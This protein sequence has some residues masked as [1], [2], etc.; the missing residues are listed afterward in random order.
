MYGDAFTYI[1]TEEELTKVFRWG[2][3]KLSGNGLGLPISYRTGAWM[4]GVNV[5]KAAQNAGF[6]IDTTG[7]TGGSI[8]QTNPN[9]LISPWNLTETTY[10]YLPSVNDINSWEGERLANL[11]ISKQRS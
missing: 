9:Y 6:L 2:R 11:G 5:L 7:R 8:S 1:Y 4:S 3:E 10:P